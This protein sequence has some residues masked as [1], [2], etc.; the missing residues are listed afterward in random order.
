MQI[1]GRWTF[2]S[3]TFDSI[4]KCPDGTEAQQKEVYS[5]D[6][7]TL[8]GSLQI[9]QGAICGE[10]PKMVEIPLRM[11]FKAP[12]AIPVTPYPLIC[13]PRRPAALLLA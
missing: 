10:Q 11:H 1:G 4:R 6:G 8:V 13:E 3:N 7:A 2:Q 9:I 12:L 5:F